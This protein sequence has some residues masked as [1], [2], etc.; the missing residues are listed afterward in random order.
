MA[1][2]HGLS[3]DQLCGFIA[4]RQTDKNDETLRHLITHVIT[5]AKPLEFRTT[6]DIRDFI[7]NQFALSLTLERVQSAVD[8]LLHAPTLMR[9]TDRVFILGADAA[10]AI[11]AA[12]NESKA[13][14]NR[15]RAEWLVD[16]ARKEL[17]I[18]P[19]QTWNALMA[20]LTTVFRQHSV[21]TLQ[22]V[23]PERRLADAHK[24]SLNAALNAAL[25]LAGGEADGDQTR[26]AIELFFTGVSGSPD[27]IE[28]M[29]RL[30]DC[31]VSYYALTVPPDIADRLRKALK[32][33]SLFLDTNALFALVGLAEQADCESVGQIAR[34]IKE[35]HIP[36]TL[37]IHDD[38]RHEL[39]D[40]LNAI[41]SSLKGSTWSPAV[42]RAAAANHTISSVQRVYHTRN[43]ESPVT[44]ESFF[45]PYEYI[46][47]L[48][49]AY[50]VVPYKDQVPDTQATYDTM[51]NYHTFTNKAKRSKSYETRHHDIRLLECIARLRSKASSS[52]DAGALFVTTDYTLY[53]FDAAE[54][55]RAHRLTLTILPTQLL[56]LLRPFVPGTADL[57]RSFAEAFASPAF[58]GTV[59]HARA[60]TAR[61]L[62]I[63]ASYRDITEEVATAVLA[64]GIIRA[65]IDAQKPIAE[66]REMVDS[67]IAQENAELERRKGQL[68]SENA[69]LR[70]RLRLS[71][72]QA[73]LRL[74]SERVATD[75]ATREI[76]ERVRRE[77]ETTEVRTAAGYAAK[78][79]ELESGLTNAKVRADAQAQIAA[80]QQRASEDQRAQVESLRARQRKDRRIATVVVA[81]TCA[82]LAHWL[83]AYVSW[84][85][86]E[87]HPNEYGLRYAF[88]VAAGLVPL[89]WIKEWRMRVAMGGV[90][91]ILLIIIQIVGG[92]RQTRDDSDIVHEAKAAHF[93]PPIGH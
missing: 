84:P 57:D 6:H 29:S 34:E 22:L 49:K 2:A 31:T 17:H 93:K 48:V 69:E 27:R 89:L 82:A 79:A 35:H 86:L 60:A 66:I 10:A 46:D 25:S 32:P 62:E 92:R 87:H 47:E 50:G 4:I 7:A 73:A 68:L 63:L 45:Q 88:D 80:D 43:A 14:E 11:Q 33:L 9:D 19:S 67:V 78:V 40:T 38:T 90:I 74:D 53:R 12:L 37:R 77:F 16:V 56:Q 5:V 52:L 28:Y 44:A 30:A 51:E 1:T 41:T 65:G 85:W 3:F 13:L 72:E 91:P 70:E 23:M 81:L 76:E 83:L 64:N 39:I 71:D 61:L 26:E 59:G 21:Q 20:Y 58:R 36:F 8:R 54:A 42:S 55:R 18:D 24:E 75:K 15:V